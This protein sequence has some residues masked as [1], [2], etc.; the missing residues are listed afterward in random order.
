MPAC[1]EKTEKV[2]NNEPTR[3]SFAGWLLSFTLTLLRK[4]FTK[5]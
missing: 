4:I 3:K 5:H 2:K 1:C